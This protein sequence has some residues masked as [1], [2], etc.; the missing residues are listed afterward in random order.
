MKAKKRK[1]LSQ[2]QLRQMAEAIEKARENK[3][4]AD[5]M[6]ALGKALGERKKN[7]N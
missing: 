2:A 3:P 7:A 6:H 1:P 4:L 5:L